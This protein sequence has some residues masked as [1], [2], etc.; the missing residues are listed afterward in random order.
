MVMKVL[1]PGR[2]RNNTDNRARSNE[3]GI[4]IISCAIEPSNNNFVIVPTD[5]TSL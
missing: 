2:I 5:N 1:Y 3:S 4:D